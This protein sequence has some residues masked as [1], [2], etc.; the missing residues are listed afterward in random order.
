[1]E[2]EGRF[3]Q[4]IAKSMKVEVL[5]WGTGRS[6]PDYVIGG[7]VSRSTGQIGWKLLNSRNE[8]IITPYCIEK[9]YRFMGLLKYRI[10]IIFFEL[11]L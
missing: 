1:M 3:L 11:L 2:E 8:V 6:R 7:Y 5:D 10:F 9:C 4:P